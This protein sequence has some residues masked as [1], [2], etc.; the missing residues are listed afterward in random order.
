MCHQVF[1]VDKINKGLKKISQFAKDS[2][3][4]NKSK[5]V[6]KAIDKSLLATN[7]TKQTPPQGYFG[8]TRSLT[9]W[10]FGGLVA[11]SILAGIHSANK[12]YKKEEVEEPYQSP[13]QYSTAYQTIY[14]PPQV[15]NYNNRTDNLGAT[16]DLPLALHR[17]RNK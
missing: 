16:G 17:L 7:I 8:V 13:P 2:S 1:D 11:G 14:G 10:G 15:G 4:I 12:D 3:A 5:K 9:K 6:M